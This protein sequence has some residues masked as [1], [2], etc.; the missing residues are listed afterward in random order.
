MW[1]PLFHTLGGLWLLL[2]PGR[3]SMLL[4][5]ALIVAA[6]A[7]VLYAILRREFSVEAGLAGGVLLIA[8]P[9]A[10]ASTAMIMGDHLCS[11]IRSAVVYLLCALSANR[12]SARGDLVRSARVPEHPG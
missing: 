7:T 1:G 8:A 6:F 2:S 3:E 12:K 10:Q 5:M 4:L 11:V 9:A